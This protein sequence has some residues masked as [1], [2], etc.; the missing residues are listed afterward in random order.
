MTPRTK[1]GISAWG[2]GE[3][4]RK[5]RVNNVFIGRDDME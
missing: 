2:L 4:I 1:A 3:L 5:T